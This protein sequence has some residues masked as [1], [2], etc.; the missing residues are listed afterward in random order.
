MKR[1]A[2]L[3]LAI[4]AVASAQPAE[5]FAPIYGVKLPAGYRDWALISVARVGS[6]LNDMR[7]KLGNDVAIKAYR[8]G[9]LPFPDGTIIARLAWNQT[10]SEENNNA[11]RGILERQFSPDV[12]QKL[13]AESFEAGPATTVQFMVKD[14]K[15]YAATS[16]WG[17]AQFTNG[18]PDGEAVHKTCFACHTP[19]ED[20]DFV[21][22]RYSR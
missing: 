22:T 14:S 8:E 4:G 6:P 7:A 3:V 19:A 18:K 5:D 2:V 10:T 17:F 20:R 9:K 13:L 1:I 15:K 11:V 21:F 16:G 12:V